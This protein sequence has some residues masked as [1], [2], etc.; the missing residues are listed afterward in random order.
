[1]FFVCVYIDNVLYFFSFFWSIDIRCWSIRSVISHIVAYHCRP[2]AIYG[3]LTVAAG[4]IDS[5]GSKISFTAFDDWLPVVGK[6]FL[7]IFF[8]IPT[9][10]CCLCSFPIVEPD[11]NHTKLR[12]SREGLE[13][14][15]RITTP[16]AAVAVCESD[17]WL[18]IN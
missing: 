7:E 17:V 4:E 9:C 14:I 5:R 15:S 11:P 2:V 1:M 18:I 13:A 6:H 16:I 12:L 3:H 8:L 10:P